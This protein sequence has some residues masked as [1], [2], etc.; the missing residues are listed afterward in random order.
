MH[1]TLRPLFLERVQPRCLNG[2][3]A[4]RALDSILGAARMVSIVVLTMYIK[5]PRRARQPSQALP[6][7]HFPVLT[8]IG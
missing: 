3:E 4:L 8:S 5:A 7:C 2:N 6:A 1:G